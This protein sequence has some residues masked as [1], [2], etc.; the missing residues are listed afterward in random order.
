MRGGA[1]AGPRAHPGEDPAGS[2]PAFRG[3]DPACHH[4]VGG[5][6]NRG[7][8]HSQTEA[9]RQQ[10]DQRGRD[11]RGRHRRQ[12]QKEGP[13]DGCQQ[14]NLTRPKTVGQAAS[15]CL[16]QG[17]PQREDAENPAELDLAQMEILGDGLAGNGNI[18]AI[19]V[20]KGAEHK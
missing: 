1:T 7:Y 4:P 20:P 17:I 16:E 18:D 19:Q 10:N 2:P 14:E 3:R 8:P 13:P 9:Q 11:A 6:V 12:A 5:R 15:G